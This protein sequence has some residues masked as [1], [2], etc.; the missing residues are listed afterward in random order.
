MAGR[1]NI[2]KFILACLTLFFATSF[3]VAYAKSLTVT[4]LSP[5]NGP[6]FVPGSVIAISVQVTDPNR[7]SKISKVDFYDNSKLIGTD[8]TGQPYMITLSNFAAGTHILKATATDNS[9]ATGSASVTITIA[10]KTLVN[11]VCGSSNG[12]R[13]SSAPTAG[14]CSAGTASAVAGNGPWLWNCIGTNG[15]TMAQCGASVAVVNG[16]CGSS[17]GQTF[18]SA[19]TTNLCN[20]GTATTVNVNGSGW[21][22]QC[23]GSIVGTA[24]VCTAQKST[25]GG[26]TTPECDLTIG[27]GS[28]IQGAINSA[29]AG[30]TFCLPAGTWH[31]QQFTPAKGDK[32]IGDP[33]GGTILTGDDKTQYLYASDGTDDLG[34]V[35]LQNITVEHYNKSVSE[36]TLGAIHGTN[37]WT[38]TNDTFTLNNCTGLNVGPNSTVTGGHYTYN[39]HAG[40]ESGSNNGP[41]IVQGAEIAWNNTR[42]DDPYNDASGLKFG[43]VINVQLLNNWV[44]NNASNGLWCD[45]NCANIIMSGNTIIG[46]GYEGIRYEVSNGPAVIEKNVV[47]NNGSGLGAGSDDQIGVY[48]SNGVQVYDNNIEVV[49]S[50][51][52][53]IVQADIRTDYPKATTQNISVANN[54]ITFVTAG[55]NG[56]YGFRNFDGPLGSGGSN[57]IISNNNAFYVPNINDL[58][59]VWNVDT[60]NPISWSS[61]RASSGQDANSILTTGNHSLTGCQSTNCTSNGIP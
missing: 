61:Y 44:H 55:S 25:S 54:I 33:N 46:N 51:D 12:L 41:I 27:V 17:N 5:V 36:C 24:A 59:W 11:G 14:L 57:S 8:K 29:S 53:I 18:S 9:G 19:P 56:D 6:S 48:S 15:G 60:A 43:A 32:F 47:N 38:F 35:V 1:K 16:A 31:Q 49:G 42:K 22:W 13:L 40:I 21:M 58:H 2:L 39:A 23:M 4:F 34:G 3:S 30:T 26:G 50:E 45:I 20:S 7:N 37:H 28:S 10:S 52:S